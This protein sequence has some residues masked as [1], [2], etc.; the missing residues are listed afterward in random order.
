MEQLEFLFNPRSVVVVGAS[1]DPQKWG[2]LMAKALVESSYK[3]KLYLVNKKGGEVCGVQAYRDIKDIPDLVDLAIIGIPARYVPQAT[4]D[5]IHQGVKMIVIVTAGFGETGEKGKEVEENLVTLAKESGIRLVG[6]NC[7]GVYNSAIDL[8]T[9]ILPITPGSLG[10]ITQSGN[11]GLEVSYL[12]RRTGLGFS[13]FISL[14]NQIDLEFHEYLD[15][16]GNDPD[17]KA[18]LLFMEGLRNGREFLKI[19]RQITRLKPVVAM[20]IGYTTT[21]RR[22][23]ISHTGSLAGNDQIYDAA[24]RQAGVIRV[25]NSNELLGL[26]NAFAKLPMPRGNRI[27]VMTEG[28]G[29]AT[30]ASDLAEGSN[31]ELPVLGAVTQK[32]LQEALLPQ[33]SIQNP[34]DFAGAAD[35]D[36]WTFVKCAEILLQDRDI[37]GLVIVGQFGGYYDLFPGAD[38]IEEQI[39]TGLIDLMDKYDKPVILQSMYA[40]ENPRSL[41]IMQSQCIPVYESV[42]TAISAMASLFMRARYLE[43]HAGERPTKKMTPIS[44]DDLSFCQALFEK[45]LSQK[46]L[47]LMEPEARNLIKRFGIPVNDFLLASTA[48]EAA[49]HARRLGFPAV[50][51]IVSQDIIHKTEAGGVILGLNSERA[52]QEGFKEIINNARHYNPEAGIEGVMVTPMETKGIEVIVGA[53]IDETFGHFVM[54]GLGGIHVEVLRDVSFRVAPITEDDAF[55]MIREI[56]GFTLLRGIR[57]QPG[58]D[59]AAIAGILTGVSEIIAQF[60]QICELDLNPVFVYEKGASVIDARVIIST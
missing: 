38:K 56:K 47:T 22:S 34:V 30:L 16:M 18:I 13:K 42:E 46:R 24:F 7:L 15:Y 55:E 19:A 17:T 41:E 27:A 54:F 8:N 6:P 29:H 12:A 50:L 32:R 52:V 26:G 44:G 2:N 28:G 48:P 9:T 36:L 58:A 5:C 11:F 25:R 51:K 21:G 37:D 45:A 59:I 49:S 39:A 57:G 43:K 4:K 3:G 60:P 14:G 40:R 10:F 23:A 20:K 35:E 53:S 31:L 33:S 1:R